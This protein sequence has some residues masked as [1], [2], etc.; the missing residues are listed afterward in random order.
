MMFTVF[1]FAYQLWNIMTKDDI[2]T[3]VK[4]GTLTEKQ[5]REIV[6]E[7]YPVND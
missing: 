4:K 6:Q 2:A 5:Y 7:E 1:K 3:E